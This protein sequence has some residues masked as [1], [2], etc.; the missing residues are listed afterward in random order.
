MSEC[1]EDVVV[2][3]LVVLALDGEDGDVVVLDQGGGSVVL[4]GEGVGG[5]EDEVGAGRLEGAAEVGRFGGDMQ[6]GAHAEAFKGPLL[7]EPLADPL[8]DGHIAVG[9]FDAFPA[10]GRQLQVLDV[11]FHSLFSPIDG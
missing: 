11:V 4:C 7:A 10:H 5:D 8:Q 6:A 9:P 2:V 3:G 1:G